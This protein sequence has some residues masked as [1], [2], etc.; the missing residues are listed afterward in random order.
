M[1]NF[2][3]LLLLCLLPLLMACP[4]SVEPLYTAYKPILM[5]RT[6]LET[7]VMKKGPLPI[8]EPGKLYRY[9][10]YIFINEQYK[11]VHVINNQNPKAPENLAFIQVPG[12]VDF[13]VKN[14]VMYVDNAVDLVAIDLQDINNIRITKRVRNALPALPPPDNNQGGFYLGDTPENAVIVGW[15]LSKTK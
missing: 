4:S 8:V 13:A 2:T 1:K 12:N 9:G 11:G 3:R 6:Q 10:N 15:E 5:S 14:N 7:S